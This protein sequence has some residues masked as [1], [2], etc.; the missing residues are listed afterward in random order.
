MSINYQVLSGSNMFGPARVHTGAASQTATDNFSFV[1]PNVGQNLYYTI[2]EDN[3]NTT[4]R[5]LNIDLVSYTV[6]N[7]G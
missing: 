5:S 1:V 3:A 6:P 2:A 4:S 7:G